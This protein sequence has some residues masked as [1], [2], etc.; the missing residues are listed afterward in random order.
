M[1]NESAKTREIHATVTSAGQPDEEPTAVRTGPAGAPDVA[2]VT[3]S[4]YV[5]DVDDMD[6]GTDEDDVIDPNAVIIGETAPVP[7][8]GDQ[9]RSPADPAPAATPPDVITDTTP[10]AARSGVTANASPVA[11]GPAG[12]ADVSTSGD[13]AHR[14]EQWT[15]I[16]ST[17]VDDPRGSVVA[18]AELVTE[19]INTL[20]SAA[21]ERERG[22]RDEW[23]RDGVD[24][25]DLRNTL[26]NYRGFLD[27]L[28]AM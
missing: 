18:A 6:D 2:N 19:A 11:A 26:R 15:A 14:Q 16:Q 25:E 20:V 10:A 24:T 12:P 7:A 5:V 9:T 3:E 17:F 28:A 22:L 27:H 1:S 21:K 4:D 13:A 8:S 23:D